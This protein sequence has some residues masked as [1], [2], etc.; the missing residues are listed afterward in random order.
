LFLAQSDVTEK[1]G[2]THKSEYSP[3]CGRPGPLPLPLP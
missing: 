3:V 2:M 1:L